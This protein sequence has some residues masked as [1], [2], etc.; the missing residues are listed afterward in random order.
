MR[1]GSSH[2]RSQDLVDLYQPVRVIGRYGQQLG[3]LT[4]SDALKFAEALGAGLARIAGV[5]APPAYRVIDSQ[6]YQL[7]L[8]KPKPKRRRR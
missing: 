1:N 5:A 7:M 8:M 4:L 6:E 2:P 3:V